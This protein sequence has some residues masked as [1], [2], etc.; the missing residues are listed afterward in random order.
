MSVPVNGPWDL[1]AVLTGSVVAVVCCFIHFIIT[2]VRHA[3]R[4]T[5][6]PVAEQRTW[7]SDHSVMEG[8]QISN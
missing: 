3:A 2:A 1:L 5:E 8:E 4:R 7:Q 6:C